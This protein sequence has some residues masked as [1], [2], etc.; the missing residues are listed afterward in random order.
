[1]A[2][3][4]ARHT[5]NGILFEWDRYKATANVRKHD[6]SFEFACEAFFD[7]FVYYIDEEFVEGEQRETILGMTSS[8]RLLYVV[9]VIRE[10]VVRII[11]ARF[12]T[13]SERE[14]YEN[15]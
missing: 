12:V 15:Q 4:D 1:M 5:L 14:Q 8:S 7:P 13:R 11:S 6:V 2:Q 3:N 10:D 9:Y